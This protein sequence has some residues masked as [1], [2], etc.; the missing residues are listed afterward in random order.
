[1]TKTLK[2]LGIG[3]GLLAAP[4]WC[5]GP[6][7]AMAAAAKRIV[8]ERLAA[9]LT[10]DAGRQ[11]IRGT[12]ALW[13]QVLLQGGVDKMPALE[14]DLRRS[15]L[16]GQLRDEGFRVMDPAKRSLA[17][18]LRPT[19]V[20]LVFY[21]PADPAAGTAAFY[22]VLANANQECTPLGGDSVTLTTWATSGDPIPASADPAA[23]AEAIR[24]SA[25]A[26]V[27]AFVEAAK[28]A[29]TE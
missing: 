3:F 23:D 2:W 11:S 24:A 1:M 8:S 13:V 4:A 5:A 18:G 14:S 29:V 27:H 19:L 25:R 22:V 12:K 20:L 28:G 15:D 6:A 7:P 21:S 10:G 17:I 16:E 9:P 26:C